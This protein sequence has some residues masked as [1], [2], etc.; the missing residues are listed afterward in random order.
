MIAMDMDGTLLDSECRMSADAVE[1]IKTAAAG[2][3]LVTI[4]T[5]RMFSSAVQYAERLGIDAPLI[6]YNGALVKS[7]VSRETYFHCPLDYALACR[8]VEFMER[9]PVSINLYFD[10]KL[11]VKEID[12][13][14]RGYAELSRVEAYPVGDLI[15]FMGGDAQVIAERMVNGRQDSSHDDN[16]RCGCGGDG[17]K[18]GP[19]KILAIGKPEDLAVIREDMLSEFKDTLYITG[20]QPQYLELMANGVSKANALQMLAKRFGIPRQNIMAV[21]DSHNDV[22]MLEY[23]GIGVAVANAVGR[24]RE[25]ADYVT[26]ALYSDGVA[27]AIRKF[28]L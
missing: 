19:T 6:T 26:S 27:E 12:D 13:R 23:A 24:A 17:T 22:E 28:V 15:A 25:E 5:G 14:V 9:Y 4:A 11:Y 7:V 3:V 10:D 1:A 8:A 18:V 21:G 16:D 2:G 20:S